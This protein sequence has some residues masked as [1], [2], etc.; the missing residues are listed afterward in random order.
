MDKKINPGLDETAD[1]ETALSRLDEIVSALENGSSRLEDSLRLFE[2][3][4]GLI[5]VCSDKLEQAEQKVKIL[6]NNGNGSYNEQ[7]FTKAE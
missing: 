1:F 3:G 2:E 4:V 6:V 7:D 5:R